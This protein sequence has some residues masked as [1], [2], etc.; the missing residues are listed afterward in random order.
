MSLT[1]VEVQR[2][3]LK[4]SPHGYDCAEA[5]RLLEEVATSYEA[6]WLEGIELHQRVE[7]LERELSRT[8]RRRGMIAALAC[9][10]AVG[11]AGFAVWL[12]W[13][14]PSGEAAVALAPQS[15]TPIAEPRGDP[16]M[17]GTAP[18]PTPTPSPK[19]E[20]RLARLFLSATGGDSWLSVQ[21][22]SAGGELL[23]LGTLARG[24]SLR[25]AE[26]RLWLRVGAPWNLVARL[27]GA[28]VRGFPNVTAGVLV[29]PKGISV[30]PG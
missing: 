15:A 19:P 10:A 7:S 29:T 13:S 20:P 9:V 21:A 17:E 5:D 28:R 25:F 4:R 1:P 23:Y 24:K 8:R 6:L 22:G 14:E 3:Q 26:K 2:V 16:P 30:V 27:N 11:A 18:K 12:W